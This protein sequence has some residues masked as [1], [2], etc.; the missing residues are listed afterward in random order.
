MVPPV[1]T[2]AI[3][4]SAVISLRIASGG[5]RPPCQQHR[6]AT[7]PVAGHK[8]IA[9]VMLVPMLR[10]PLRAPPLANEMPVNPYVPMTIPTVI[11][12]SP[13]ESRAWR[14]YYDH[15]RRRRSDPDFDSHPAESGRHRAHEHRCP[16]SGQ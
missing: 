10:Y 6:S 11:P 3:G 13:N 1:V 15:T 9:P 7:L 14:R 8:V 2:T 16:N 4:T 12:R 5:A